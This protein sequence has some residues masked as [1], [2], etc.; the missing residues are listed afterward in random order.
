[1]SQQDLEKLIHV[2]I[3][4]PMNYYNSVFTGLPKEVHQTAAADPE[5]CCL[6]PH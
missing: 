5:L 2:F 6:R 4:S 3:S 1:M